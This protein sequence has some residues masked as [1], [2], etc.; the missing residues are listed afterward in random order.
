MEQVVADSIVED[1]ILG[2]A[3]RYKYSSKRP[4]VSVLLNVVC[5][6]WC[7][8]Q[9]TVDI[10]HTIITED[11]A[12]VPYY[13]LFRRKLMKRTWKGETP[14]RK[15]MSR[16][17]HHPQGRTKG[18]ENSATWIKETS[19]L[20]QNNTK[21]VYNLSDR[22]FSK[23]ANTANAVLQE[24]CTI[25]KNTCSPK[26]ILNTDGPQYKELRGQDAAS[27][28]DPMYKPITTDPRTYMEKT[29]RT[30][31]NNAPLRG[32]TKKSIIS[33]EK[34]LKLIVRRI[35]SPT[36]ALSRYLA[37]Q[38]K[39][40]GEQMASY[41][42]NADHFIDILAQQHVKSTDML[43]SF[44]VTSLFTQVPINE[45]IDIIRNKH[46]VENHPI[47]LIEYCMKSTYFI[48]NGQTY[49]QTEGAPMGSPLLPIIANIFMGD[50]K[51]RTLDT[52]KYKHKLWL[53]YVNNTFIIWTHGEDKL[54]S[55]TSIVSI[56][57]SS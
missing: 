10:L 22:Q 5:P 27:S 43:V 8:V 42:K 24:I 16:K 7:S 4:R 23:A 1:F 48:C 29:T 46:Q 40:H 28:K 56:Q 57:R 17:G 35:R 54:H 39:P 37:N 51:T 11:E 38:L 49:R 19:T 45:T 13:A 25:L 15:L 36:Q 33:R 52:A 44:D 50:F 26:K 6:L 31:I 2:D 30:K 14:S 12:M 18:E 55:R 20:P 53:R 3:C 34:S 21:V 47:N 41:V 32:E 9:K